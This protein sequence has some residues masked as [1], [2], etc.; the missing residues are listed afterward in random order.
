MPR[1]PGT[2]EYASLPEGEKRE[3]GQAFD[4]ALAEKEEAY[5]R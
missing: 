5:G 4:A 3:L 1:M 2:E